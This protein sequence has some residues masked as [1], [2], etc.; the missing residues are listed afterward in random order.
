MVSGWIRPVFA[1]VDPRWTR[2]ELVHLREL[3]LGNDVDA[4][5]GG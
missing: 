2:Q 3:D 4:P 5:E 1:P